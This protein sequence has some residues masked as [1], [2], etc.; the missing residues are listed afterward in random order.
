MLEI[1]QTDEYERS[2]EGLRDLNAQLRIGARIRRDIERAKELAR[3][4]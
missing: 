1:R 4:L 2:F 3:G